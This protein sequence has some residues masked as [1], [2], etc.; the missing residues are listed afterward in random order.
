M[1][2]KAII[3]DK[4]PAAVGPYSH[5]YLVGDTLYTSGQLGLIPE[6]GE[7]AEGVAEQAKRGLENLNAVLEAA[8]FSRKD[9]VKTSVF[10][11]NMADFAAVNDI[12]AEFFEGQTEYPA[13]SCVQ[14]AALPK[15]AL[16][17]IE[18]IAV[19]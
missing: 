15:A 16:F 12:Y 19:K 13:R 10:L 8:G 2:K 6:T 17:E 14:V 9:I 3:A 1:N 4:A 7:L 11:A 18:A 5:A